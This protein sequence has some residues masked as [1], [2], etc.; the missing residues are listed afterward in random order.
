MVLSALKSVYSFEA[1]EACNLGTYIYHGFHEMCIFGLTLYHTD[2]ISI[3]MRD[4]LSRAYKVTDI[5]ACP[6]EDVYKRNERAS[7]CV[8]FTRYT[9]VLLSEFSELDFKQHFINFAHPTVNHIV[10]D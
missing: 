4:A 8:S 5:V 7:G 2:L 1:A 6:T 9:V 3:Y 10:N